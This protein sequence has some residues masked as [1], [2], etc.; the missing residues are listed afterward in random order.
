MDAVIATYVA[1]KTNCD[2][3]AVDLGKLVTDNMDT[4]VAATAYEH[5]H[6]ADKRVLAWSSARYLNAAVPSIN[7]CGTNKAYAAVMSMIPV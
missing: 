4:F 3:L 2:K 1:D 7:A 5:A 6:P